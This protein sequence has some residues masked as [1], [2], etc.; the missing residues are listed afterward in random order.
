MCKGQHFAHL[1]R[2]DGH[3]P[4]LKHQ[5]GRQYGRQKENEGHLHGLQLIFCAMVE[6]V[7]PTLRLATINTPTMASSSV[8]LTLTEE[9]LLVYGTQDGSKVKVK[10]GVIDET[11]V[12]LA[13]SNLFDANAQ[14]ERKIGELDDRLLWAQGDIDEL[15]KALAL[16]KEFLDFDWEEAVQQFLA[17]HRFWMSDGIARQFRARL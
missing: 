1:L 4:E 13:L 8:K 5:A 6:K 10:K 2:A 15:K 9:L 7:K 12:P 14:Q 11:K 16:E 17:S 3:N